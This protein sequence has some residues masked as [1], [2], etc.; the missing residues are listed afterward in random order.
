[1]FEV[2]QHDFEVVPRGAKTEYEFK[3]TNKY[4]ETVHVASVRTSCKCTIPR[5]GKNDLKTYEEG[6]IIAEFKT[7]DFVGARSA[8]ITVVFDRPYYAE[9]QLIVKGNIR[10]DILPEPGEIQFG[11]VDLGAEKVTDV[12][13]SYTG[14]TKWEIRDVLSKNEHLA[15]KLSQPIN[16]NN[17]IEYVMNVRLKNSA[18]AGEFSDEIVLVT[19]EAQSN[20]VTLPVRA[21]VVP[22]L[23]VEG[24]QLGTLQVGGTKNERLLVKAKVPFKIE[25]IECADGRFTFATPTEEKPVH[26]IKFDFKADDKVG[27]FREKVIVHT[28]LPD[29]ATAEAYITGNVAQ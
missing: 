10:S 18:T 9:L 2:T 26:L 19:N 14:P 5:I 17:K 28:T 8:V 1:M 15:V 12:K 13:I 25:K 7:S 16:L 20:R 22:P 11:E 3:F 27:S 23:H 21:N 6:S 4:K 24:V 29:S